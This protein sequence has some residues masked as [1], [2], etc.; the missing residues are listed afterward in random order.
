MFI[1]SLYNLK[2]GVGKTAACVNF[3]Y[4]AAKNGYRVLLWDLDPQG[5]ASFYYK[6]QPKVKA[7]VK[8]IIESA[9]TLDEAIMQT[10]YERLDIIPADISA[11]KMDLLLEEQNS[12]KKYLKNLLKSLEDDYDFVF[13]DCPPGFYLVAENVFYAS[14]AVLMPVIPTTLSIRTYELVKNYFE[15]KAIGVEKLMCFFSMVDIRKN[16][17]NDVMKQL[18]KDKHFFEYYIPTLSDIEKMG[19]HNAP[20]EAFA[21]SSYATTCYKALWNEIKEGVLE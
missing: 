9:S 17:H 18:Y 14:D 15:D 21:P 19:L 4:M 11:R 2:G 12:S 16:M 5:A 10:D 7:N 20:V 8:K 3:S 1:A 6:A 13:I